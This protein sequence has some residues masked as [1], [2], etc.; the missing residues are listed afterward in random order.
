MGINTVAVETGGKQLIVTFD[1]LAEHEYLLGLQFTR[2]EL[3][4]SALLSHRWSGDWSAPLEVDEFL[5]QI[6]K[7]LS[8]QLARVI[9]QNYR[10]RN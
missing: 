7:R 6:E 3:A 10:Q 1:R 5:T 2:A 9:H 8:Y 4:E